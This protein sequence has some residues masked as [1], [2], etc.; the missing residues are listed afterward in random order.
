M[1]LKEL[2][3]PISPVEFFKDYWGQKAVV[4]N[5]SNDKFSNLFSWSKLNDLLNYSGNS[6]PY[7]RI[8]D[9][10]TPIHEDLLLDKK[11]LSEKLVRKID[12]KK[13][14]DYCKKGATLVF[15]KSE[16]FDKEIKCLVQDLIFEIGEKVQANLYCS[17]TDHQ[18]FDLHY[19]THEVILLQVEGCKKWKVYS[20]IRKFPIKYQIEDSIKPTADEVPCLDIELK[21]G[22]VLYIPRGHYHAGIAGKDPSI[23]ITLGVNCRT[24]IT[25]SKFLTDYLTENVLWRKNAPLLFAG[26]LN[27]DAIKKNATEWIVELSKNLLNELNNNK[28][29]L[30]QS[31]IEQCLSQNKDLNYYNLPIQGDGFTKRISETT[32]FTRPR[33]QKLLAI[34]NNSQQSFYVIIDSKRLELNTKLKKWISCLA[35]SYTFSGEDAK[36]WDATLTWESLKVV[37]ASFVDN[38][39]LKIKM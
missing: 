39:I 16:L 13:V 9:H 3:H 36:S 24:G 33:S 6:Y 17:W 38:D 28:D 12:P 14:V 25:F 5:G 15:D 20:D 31:Y 22:E 8:V 37:L 26:K 19:D 11:V 30:V 32:I 7:L 4:I 18:G 34:N 2:L 29:V 27:H 21:A 1:T 10:K 35:E 23:H